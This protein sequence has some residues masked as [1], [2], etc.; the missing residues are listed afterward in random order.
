MCCRC[1]DSYLNQAYKQIIFLA[2]GQHAALQ[3]SS[4]H[5]SCMCGTKGMNANVISPIHSWRR[6]SQNKLTFSW[7]SHISQQFISTSIS[8]DQQHSKHTTTYENQFRKCILEWG[9]WVKI[10][11]SEHGVRA[12]ANSSQIIIVPLVSCWAIVPVKDF[13]IR[14][15]RLTEFCA[16]IKFHISGCVANQIK[17]KQ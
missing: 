10:R 11:Q 13:Q 14:L 17:A 16:S 2:H 12:L 9:D 15:T 1:Q 8:I 3:G 5:R 4:A 6:R 7:I